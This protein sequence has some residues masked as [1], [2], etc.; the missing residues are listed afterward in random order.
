MSAALCGLGALGTYTI[1][2]KVTYGMFSGAWQARI[3]FVG[4]VGVAAVIYVVMLSVLKGFVE[5]DMMMLPKGA[6]ICSLLRKIKA[7]K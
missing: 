2:E 1:L 3:C 4:A 6:K 5:E 7:M